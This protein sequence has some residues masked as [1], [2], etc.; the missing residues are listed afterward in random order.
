MIKALLRLY[1]YG[2]IKALL[3]RYYKGVRSRGG[4]WRNGVGDPINA[5]L[6]RLRD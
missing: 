6:S 1:D 3:R 5:L 2:S 4:V